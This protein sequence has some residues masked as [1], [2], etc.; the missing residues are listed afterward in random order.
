MRVFFPVV[1]DRQ[2]LESSP[3]APQPRGTAL[4][5]GLV[6]A[7]QIVAPGQAEGGFFVMIGR[8]PGRERPESEDRQAAIAKAREPMRH[9]THA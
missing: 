6:Q 3:V 2:T 4:E 1:E 7:A 5:H 8:R 9:V